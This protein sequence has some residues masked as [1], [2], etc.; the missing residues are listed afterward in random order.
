MVPSGTQRLKAMAQEVSVNKDREE[1]SGVKRSDEEEGSNVEDVEEIN[2][3][4]H[5][6]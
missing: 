6:V 5:E 3:G 2:D 1:K 4:Q